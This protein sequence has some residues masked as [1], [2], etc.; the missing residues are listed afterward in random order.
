MDRI[1]Q[2]CKWLSL[3]NLLK[4]LSSLI[5]LSFR[6]S[7]LGSLCLY[8]ALLLIYNSIYYLDFLKYI[9]EVYY[10]FRVTIVY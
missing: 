4:N 9:C 8:T 2:V 7:Y 10:S 6:F 3:T 1:Q 5:A